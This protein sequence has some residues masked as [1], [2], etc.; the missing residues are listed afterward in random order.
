MKIHN[1]FLLT[2][3]YFNPNWM[4]LRK[5]ASM[6]WDESEHPRDEIGRFAFKNGGANEE[7]NKKLL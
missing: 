6:T 2:L 5:E 1:G 7:E 3:F 4:D